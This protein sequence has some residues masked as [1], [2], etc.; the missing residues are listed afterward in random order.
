MAMPDVGQVYAQAFEASYDA[1]LESSDVQQHEMDAEQ[2]HVSSS[3]VKAHKRQVRNLLKHNDQTMVN[4]QKGE[5]Y[6]LFSRPEL[7][8]KDGNFSSWH[9]R[10]EYCVVDV[11]FEN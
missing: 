10:N 6:L 8:R 9:Y 7:T 5:V 11:F 4:L 1:S 3:M 2:V